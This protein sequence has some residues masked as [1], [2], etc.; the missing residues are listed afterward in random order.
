MMVT[1]ALFV[2]AAQTVPG[3]AHQVRPTLA[4]TRHCLCG[5]DST[6]CGVQRGS[7]LGR[8]P[9][10][11]CCCDGSYGVAVSCCTLLT[12]GSASVSPIPPPHPPSTFGASILAWGLVVWIRL[13][14]RLWILLWIRV[15]IRL[16][17]RLWI[18]VFGYGFGD[19]TGSIC[20]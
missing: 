2:S 6:W 8:G 7:V 10:A 16:W 11:T 5:T 19:G 12:D 18:R 17:V 9:T 1:S 4:R 3:A 13:W 15:W 20:F 14:I